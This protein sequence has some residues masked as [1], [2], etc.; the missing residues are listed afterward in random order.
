MRARELE[1]NG[2]SVQLRFEVQDT[3]VGIEPENL[4]SVF[5]MFEQA[6]TSTTRKHGGTGLGLAITRRLA[7]VMGGK[8]GVESVLGQGSTFWF[9]AR[10]TRGQRI[11]QENVPNQ[12]VDAETI[13]QTQF[14]GSRILLVEDNAINCEV[15]T[16]LLSVWAWLSRRRT[17]VTKRCRWYGIM[18]INWY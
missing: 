7:Q 1:S 9:T 16:A 6:D 8:V 2:D 13:L 17:M 18:R 15:A 10:F 11:E 3:G 5:G 12:H 14:A 4:S